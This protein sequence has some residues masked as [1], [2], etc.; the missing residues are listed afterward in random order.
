MPP[1]KKPSKG[2]LVTS[3]GLPLR[4]EDSCIALLLAWLSAV[5]LF[6]TW[7]TD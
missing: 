2:E 6:I 7:I 3:D 5:L 4:L 1:L